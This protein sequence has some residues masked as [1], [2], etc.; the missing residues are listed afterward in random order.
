LFRRHTGESPGQNHPL[1]KIIQ[2]GQD[3]PVASGIVFKAF[4]GFPIKT[5]GNN[6]RKID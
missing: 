1:D 2:D 3:R 6:N 4:Y 5:F